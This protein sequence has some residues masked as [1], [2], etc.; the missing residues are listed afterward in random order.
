MNQDLRRWR[1]VVWTDENS[2]EVKRLACHE[3]ELVCVMDM[4]FPPASVV[5]EPV[6]KL[7]NIGS[8][9]QFYCRFPY[10]VGDTFVE[11]INQGDRHCVVV[12]VDEA[13]GDY[14]YDYEMPGGK[15]FLRN[16]N[17]KPISRERIPRKFQ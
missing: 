10:Q 8:N 17:K 1:E 7:T 4:P 5:R 6:R 11:N 2:R 15:K 14:L 9:T 13:T 12:A 16:Q 3:S